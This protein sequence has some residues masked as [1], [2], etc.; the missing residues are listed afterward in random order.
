MNNLDFSLLDETLKKYSSSK[1]HLITIL[2]HAQ[3]LFGH[4][5]LE[6]IAYIAKKTK[7]KPAF[8][9]GVA[10]FYTQFKSS[11]QGKF[12]ISLCSGTACH[13]NGATEIYLSLSSYLGIADGQTTKDGLFTL[14]NVACLGCC[15]LAPAMAINGKTYGKLNSQSAIEIIEEIKSKEGLAK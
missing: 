13:V 3:K 2:Q 9:Q 5:P 6:L 12:L 7:I 8:I 1:E 10:S 15:S 11:K 4:I 14:Q